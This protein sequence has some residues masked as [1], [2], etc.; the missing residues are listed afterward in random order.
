MSVRHVAT[1][2]LEALQS[3]RI[4]D[5]PIWM[6]IKDPNS[7]RRH[8]SFH[9]HRILQL[10]ISNGCQIQHLICYFA[11]RK[12]GKA[13]QQLMHSPRGIFVA[14]GALS[15]LHLGTPIGSLKDTLVN[16]LP[17]EH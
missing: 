2:D 7:E 12:Y 9:S 15:V 8:V 3:V 11:L 17:I 10:Y 5:K 6:R 14:L 4:S 16:N 1:P 13:L